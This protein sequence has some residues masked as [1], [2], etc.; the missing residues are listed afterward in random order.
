[1]PLRIFEPR[2]LDMVKQCVGGQAE[3]VICL[4][5]DGSEIGIA[6][7]YKTGTACRIV[8]WETLPDGL[9]GVTAQGIQRVEINSSQVQPNQLLVG[10]IKRLSEFDDEPLPEEFDEWAQLLS[11]II[12]QLG[13]PF[14]DQTQELS[15]ARWV[16]ARL[17]EYLPFELEK[18]Q[19]ILEVD[20]PLVRLKHLKDMLKDIEYY[21]S[22]GNLNN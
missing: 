5:K 18:K 21:Y 8:D 1:M 3:F 22:Q 11:V 16:S 19:R 17:T 14:N 10:D 12:R 6:K 20:H 4:I 13:K 9:L 2:Y 7:H 15:S